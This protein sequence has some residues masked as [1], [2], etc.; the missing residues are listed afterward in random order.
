MKMALPSGRLEDASW[1]WLK[2][3]GVLNGRR[4]GRTLLWS[5][6]G[7]EI[8]VVRSRDIPRLLASRAV[9]VAILGR[10]VAAE[11]EEPLWVSDSLGFGECRLMLALPKRRE[12]D[13]SRSWRVAT[14]YTGIAARWFQ[15]QG[16]QAELVSMSGSVEVA[17]RLGLAD[18]VVDV[19]ETG[20]TMRQNGL[21]PVETVF[22]S[23]AVLVT[24]A[25]ESARTVRLG[26]RP[27]RSKEADN[28]ACQA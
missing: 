2:N 25:G 4:Q 28:A 10:D 13:T 5:S 20:E 9:D 24:R 1:S 15:E 16:V 27:D 22:Q 12:W 23:Y 6:E 14:R 8:A 21:R 18:A 3:Q 17:P 11:W 19:V 26:W 7:L